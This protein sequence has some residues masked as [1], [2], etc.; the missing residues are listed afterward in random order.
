MKSRAGSAVAG[1][2]LL[3]G[4]GASLAQG[5][6]PVQLRWQAPA[7]CPQEAQVKQK[8]SDLLR[9]GA[10]DAA[11]SRLRAEGKIEAIG[12][13]FRLT[14]TVHYDL[15]NGTRTVEAGSC[16]DLAGVAAVTLALLLRAEHSSNTPLTARDLG[17]ASGATFADSS[18]AGGQERTPSPTP[19]PS[20]PQ[21][22]DEQVRAAAPAHSKPSRF[23]L[24]I[25]VPELRADVGVL[26][27]P[28]YG[29]GL[30]L[31]VRRADWRFMVSGLWWLEHDYESG[32]FVGYGAHF[33]RLSGE[34]SA[35]RGWHLSALE[36]APCLLLSFDGVSA[37][38]TGVGVSST[39]PWTPWLSVGAGFQGHWHFN[40]MLS[41]VLGLNGR[42]ATSKPHFV[43]EGV[44]EIARVGPAALALLLGAEWVL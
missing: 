12:D 7:A 17:G 14:L 35:C 32:V 9:P 39:N 19:A 2:S 13:R 6:L 16:G 22:S 23:R 44:G 31:G 38:A 37:R 5:A 41:L 1:F 34:L 30:A 15:V 40:R 42:I 10:A 29:I 11:F 21:T 8:L 18:A 4:T 25:R 28:S 20:A 26:P 36:L 43:S 27:E 24:A 33:A 3:L